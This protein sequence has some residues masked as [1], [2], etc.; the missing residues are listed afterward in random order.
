M[1]KNGDLD[2][3]LLQKMTKKQKAQKKSKKS[4]DNPALI[5]YTMQ[6][7]AQKWRWTVLENWIARDKYE[8]KDT[9]K[10][11]V[12]AKNISWILKEKIQL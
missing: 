7:A 4:L 3:F 2:L 8:A 5:C 12:C 9:R 10:C 6:V 1:H 11:V